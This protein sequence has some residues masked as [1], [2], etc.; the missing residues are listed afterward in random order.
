MMIQLMTEKTGERFDSGM[1]A[2]V[3]FVGPAF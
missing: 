3:L 1:S 2:S